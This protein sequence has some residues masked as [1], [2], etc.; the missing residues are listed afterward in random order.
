MDWIFIKLVFNFFFLFLSVI[1]PS[2]AL[3]A[4]KTGETTGKTAFIKK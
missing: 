1:F 2:G 4:G 3:R